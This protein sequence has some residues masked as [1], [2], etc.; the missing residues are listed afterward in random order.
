MP[1]T[2]VTTGKGEEAVSTPVIHRCVV[3]D[4]LA[5]RVLA[6]YRDNPAHR[7]A[8]LL[9]CTEA[10]RWAVRHIS[11][12]QIPW[13]ERVGEAVGIDELRSPLPVMQRL[14]GVLEADQD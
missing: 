2:L 10:G 9:A 1:P 7:C 3:A 6:R 4:L 8:K 14:I 11:V 5:E 12:A 13:A